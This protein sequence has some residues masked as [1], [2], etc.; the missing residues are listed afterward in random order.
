MELLIK[1]TAK[2]VTSIG[3]TIIGSLGVISAYRLCESQNSHWYWFMIVTVLAMLVQGGISS[4][5]EE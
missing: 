3:L 1:K 4:K 2:I 5:D